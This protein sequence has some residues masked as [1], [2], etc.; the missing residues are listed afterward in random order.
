MLLKVSFIINQNHLIYVDGEVTNS[1]L[2]MVILCQ[3]D[4]E[5]SS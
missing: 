4:L 2:Q 3:K 5:H 1:A